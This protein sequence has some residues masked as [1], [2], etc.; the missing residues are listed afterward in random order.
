MTVLNI[1]FFNTNSTVL[2]AK[3]VQEKHGY[4]SVVI[5]LWAWTT[6][7]NTKALCRARHRRKTENDLHTGWIYDFSPIFPQFFQNLPIFDDF[8][9]FFF[10]GVN[11]WMTPHWYQ[12]ALKMWIWKHFFKNLDQLF[13]PPKNVPP[14]KFEFKENLGY[15]SSTGE[16]VPINSVRS[17]LGKAKK[18][19][20]KKKQ[21]VR[22]KHKSL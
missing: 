18:A 21:R 19:S 2:Y 17:A 12:V 9:R 14:P 11:E 10:L 4:A 15:R 13:Q 20:S 22:N 3:S 8:S 7:L 1:I 16:S 6:G 5:P